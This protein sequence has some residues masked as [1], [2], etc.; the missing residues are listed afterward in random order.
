[1]FF[2]VKKIRVQREFLPNS[3]ARLGRLFCMDSRNGYE[4]ILCGVWT[5]DVFRHGFIVTDRNIYWRF[6][7]GKGIITGQIKKE[8]LD[9]VN[10][11]LQRMLAESVADKEAIDGC[12]DTFIWMLSVTQGNSKETLYFNDIDEAGAKFLCDILKFAFLNGIV[13]EIDLGKAAVYS[14]QTHFSDAVDAVCNG[15]DAVYS[16]FTV[17]TGKLRSFLENEGNKTKRKKKRNEPAQ[18]KTVSQKETKS[19]DA[20]NNEIIA[21]Q[22]REISTAEREMPRQNTQTQSDA[23]AT[24]T[25]NIK[26]ETSKHQPETKE[27]IEQEKEQKINAAETASI[28]EKAESKISKKEKSVKHFTTP[29]WVLNLLDALSGIVFFAALIFALKPSLPESVNFDFNLKILQLA[30]FIGSQALVISSDVPRAELPGGDAAS[31]L[32]LAALLIYFVLKIV[33]VLLSGSHKKIVSALLLAMMAASCFVLSKTFLVF[34]IFYVLLYASF[35][36]VTDFPWHSIWRK[37]LVLAVL[38]F[39]LYVSLHI[40]L[41][42]DVYKAFENLI[43]IFTRKL[44]LGT[45]INWF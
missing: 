41:D 2:N 37:V 4:K 26:S 43:N 7:T 38:A 3:V 39:A 22:P 27:N 34:V 21:E 45:T 12:S 36:L 11:E 17:K 29:L 44:A 5:S 28:K 8:R 24:Q 13:P 20:Q 40:V 33:V 23:S 32:I 14:E 18:E 9:G 16:F 35:E 42:E 15:Y 31:V 10:F 19:A 25:E 30:K 6:V 1:M